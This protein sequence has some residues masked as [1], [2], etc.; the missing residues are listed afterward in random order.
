M[1]TVPTLSLKYHRTF[2]VGEL[3]NPAS[4][5][6]SL[7]PGVYEVTRCFMPR[8]PNGDALVLLKGRRTPI[9]TA[10]LMSANA[11][12]E[13]IDPDN[14]PPDER[15][16][17]ACQLKFPLRLIRDEEERDRALGVRD[18]LLA[19]IHR[20]EAVE[21]YLRTLSLL[22][23]TYQR[24]DAPP[25]PY[26]SDA[27]VFEFLLETRGVSANEVARATGIQPSS[28]SRVRT[29]QSQF[30][31]AQITVLAAYFNVEPSV[32][33][34]RPPEPEGIPMYADFDAGQRSGYPSVLG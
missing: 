22:I 1:K 11:E 18:A 31:R 23:D 25:P 14:M 17:L 26:D 32:F 7:R 28:L 6:C 33:F 2:Q 5:Q 21:G 4:P 30:S 19:Q 24:R 8:E 3:V 10:H 29:A 9:P 27:E 12:Q 15:E 20:S 16:F 13:F 34:R